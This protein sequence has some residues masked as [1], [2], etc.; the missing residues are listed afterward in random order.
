MSPV[1]QVGLLLSIATGMAFILAL[2]YW[3]VGVR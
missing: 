1:N 3:F 2:A